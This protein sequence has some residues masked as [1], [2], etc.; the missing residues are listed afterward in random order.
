MSLISSL[1]IGRNALAVQQ[2][3]IQVTTNNIANAGNPDYT[4]QTAGISPNND[5]QYRPGLFLGT[6]VN[7]TSVNRQIDNALLARLRGATSDNAGAYT[8]Q[9]WLARVESVFNALGSNGLSSQMSEFF[10]GWSKLAGSPQD[11]GLRQ[12]VLT[13]GTTLARSMNDVRRQLTGLRTDLDHRIEAQA[14][15]ADDLASRIADLN[16]RITVSEGGLSGQ[17]NGLRDQRDALIR[18]LSELMDVSTT[19]DGNSVNVFVGSQPLVLGTT[20]RGVSVRQ[21]TGPGGVETSLVFREDGST[22]IPVKG[23]ELGGLMSARSTVLEITGRLDGVAKSLIFELNKLHSS[24]QGLTGITTVSST[25]SVLNAGARLDSAA[26]GLPFPVQNG[27]FVVTVTDNATGLTTSKLIR[28][29]LSP[30]ASPPTSLNDLAAQLADSN[31]TA[32]VAGGQLTIG[33]ASPDV[34]LTFSQDSSGI[35]AALGINTF[36]TGTDAA[37]IAVNATLAA[38][39]SLLAAARNSSPGDNQTALAIAALDTQRFESAGGLTLRQIYDTMISNIAASTSS[40]KTVAEGTAL[41]LQTLQAQR[42]ALSGVSL[43]EESINLIKQQRAFQGA[44]RIIST[45]DELMQTVL[46]LVR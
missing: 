10:N 1:N 30:G 13:N 46:N 38:N 9:S 14:R 35:L 43:D 18:Q 4:R 21:T 41:V 6:G 3:A 23:G 24:G 33:A 32:T 45:V 39:P 34:T 8:A 2:A 15:N 27:S 37:T 25:N 29:D 7:L 26:A 44:A 19:V 36:F 17:A 5:Q 28:V 11:L 42:E 40:A 31:I 20:A 16:S 22:V 12:I